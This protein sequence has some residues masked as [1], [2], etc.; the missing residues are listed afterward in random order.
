[1]LT[2]S[3]AIATHLIRKSDKASTLLG[4]SS[5]FLEAQVNQYVAMASSAVMPRVKIIED[6]VFGATVNPEA[7]LA[8]VK[9]LKETCKVL[10][11]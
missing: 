9:D 1:M 11:T 3:T 7:N 6:T 2:D 5:P 8:A 10:D 4:T